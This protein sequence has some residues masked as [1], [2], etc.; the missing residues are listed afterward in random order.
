VV[1]T[2]VNGD[3]RIDL[4]VASPSGGGVNVLLGRGDGTFQE[5]DRV[6]ADGGAVLVAGDFN[7]DGSADLAIADQS[8]A[9]VGVLLGGGDGTFQPAVRYGPNL[10]PS[11]VAA[12]DFNGDGRDDL[13]AVNHQLEAKSGR[14]VHGDVTVLV[15]RDAGAFRPAVHYGTGSDPRAVAVGD[16]NGD[17]RADVVV[18]NTLGFDLSVLLN[19]PPGST[20]TMHA[21]NMTA[22]ARLGP[23]R[24]DWQVSLAI[25]AEGASHRALPGTI[26]TG[27]WDDGI[28]GSCVTGVL[29]TCAMTRL[30]V[31][32]AATSITFTI[33]AL[34]NPTHPEYAYDPSGNHDPDGSSDGTSMTVSKP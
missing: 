4:A 25:R 33:T 32:A 21:G 18:A 19:G 14:L 24:S 9:D 10:I 12:A 22:H 16:L 7:A 27:T 30:L 1:A 5:A 31:P 11:S 28:V 34:S 6:A 3:H 26:V 13:A 8:T 17:G 2:D 23:N 15:A 29:G 20:T